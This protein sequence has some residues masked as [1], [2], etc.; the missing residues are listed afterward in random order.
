MVSWY[1]STPNSVLCDQSRVGIS[2]AVTSLTKLLWTFQESRVYLIC[3]HLTI[4][5]CCHS[6]PQSRLS[7]HISF[8]IIAYGACTP[9]YWTLKYIIL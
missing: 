3:C 9:T 1:P 6:R 4:S 5:S 7:F 8:N 2:K